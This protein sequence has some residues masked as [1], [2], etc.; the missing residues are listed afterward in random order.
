MSLIS[1]VARASRRRAVVRQPRFTRFLFLLLLQ[2]A[3]AGCRL[4][5]I[6]LRQHGLRHGHVLI[7][8][9]G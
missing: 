7:G 3:G 9:S 2:E 1:V 5:V 6:G 4:H 8:C